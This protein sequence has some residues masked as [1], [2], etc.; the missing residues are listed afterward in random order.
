[1]SF[2]ICFSLSIENKNASAITLAFSSLVLRVFILPASRTGRS[3][4]TLAIDPVIVTAYVCLVPSAVGTSA[5]SARCTTAIVPDLVVR[6]PIVAVAVVP[7][8]IVSNSVRG[9]RLPLRIGA[10]G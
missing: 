2:T 9:P 8:G 4:I 10:I 7:V 5:L 3:G 6:A 1:M